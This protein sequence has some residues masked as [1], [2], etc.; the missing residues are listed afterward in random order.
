MLFTI[1]DSRIIN[2]VSNSIRFVSVRG[3]W[4]FSNRNSLA[5]YPI[6]KEGWFTVVMEGIIMVERA[7]LSNPTTTTSLGTFFPT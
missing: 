7:M 4:S 2:S 6:W 5:R 3:F 1:L